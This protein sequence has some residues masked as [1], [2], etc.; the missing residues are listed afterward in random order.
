MTETETETPTR[1]VLVTFDTQQA[2]EEWIIR[3]PA[4]ADPAWIMENYGDCEWVGLNECGN[5]SMTPTKMEE[6][7]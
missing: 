3:V 7:D 2:W 5:T 1:D 6:I 4:D